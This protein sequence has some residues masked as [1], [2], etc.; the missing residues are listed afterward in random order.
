MLHKLACIHED[1]Q[2]C[3]HG[4]PDV[5]SLVCVWDVSELKRIQHTEL[6]NLNTSLKDTETSLSVRRV[7]VNTYVTKEGINDN[8]LMKQTPLASN[9]LSKEKKC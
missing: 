8:V 1:E 7:N 9:P 4:Q 5:C 6:E 3:Y 2:C